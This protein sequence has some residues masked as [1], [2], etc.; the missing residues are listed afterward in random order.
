M[1]NKYIIKNGQIPN[2]KILKNEA[3][4]KEIQINQTHHL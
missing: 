4:H 2:H 3:Y 1:R